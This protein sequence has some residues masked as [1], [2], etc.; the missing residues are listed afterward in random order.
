[1]FLLFD[2]EPPYIHWCRAGK[3]GS[4]AN[5]LCRFDGKSG[6]QLAGEIGN[7]GNVEAAAYLLHHGG[8]IITR[9]LTP[10][11]RATLGNIGECVPL[12]PEYNALTFRVVDTWR[13]WM[14]RIPHFLFCNTA[15][16]SRLPDVAGTYA[17]PEVLRKKDV[18]RFGGYGLFHEWAWRQVSHQSPGMSGRVISVYL[19]NRTNIAAIRGGRAIDTTIGFT[20]V[21]GIPSSTSSGDI[22]TTVVFELFSTGMSFVEINQLLS[23]KSGFSG[24]LGRKCTFSD[25]LAPDL[26]REKKAIYDVLLYDIMKYL[27]AFVSLLGGVDAVVFC[28]ENLEE[29]YGLIGDICRSLGFMGV[30]CRPK[31]PRGGR[32]PVRN[33]S[34]PGSPVMI[35]GLE[36]DKWSIMADGIHNVMNKEI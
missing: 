5:G 4:F 32:G 24:L 27:G 13:R 14:P 22:D 31:T 25:L 9:T 19:G 1:M 10:I 34:A 28:S 26:N 2:P 36:N 6:E 3:K 7:I 16:F 20:P 8:G 23:Q 21:E 17:V 35:M 11:T 29:T 18:R 15:F 33:L 30:K 12:L